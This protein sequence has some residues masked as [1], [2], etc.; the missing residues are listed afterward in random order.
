MSE[1]E[2]TEVEDDTLSESN[3][4]LDI[5]VINEII[6]HEGADTLSLISPYGDGVNWA[7]AKTGTFQVGQKA[8]WIDSVNDPLVPVSNPLFAHM[9]KSA[10]ASG[11]A[12]VKA[13]KLRGVKSRGL[14]IPFDA[15]WEGLTGNQIAKILGIEK[16]KDPAIYGFGGSGGSFHTG[17]AR[18]GPTHLLPT[19]KYDVEGLPKN[20]KMFKN[21]MKVVLTEKVHG[22]N[23]CF[24]YLPFEKQVSE[25]GTVSFKTEFFARSRTLWK[26]PP[27]EDGKNVSLWWDVAKYHDLET[28]LAPYPGIVLWGEAY[29]QVQDLKY[30]LDHAEL[31]VFDVWD[32]NKNRWFTWNE[33][34]EF[35]KTIGLNHVPVIAEVEWNS[36]KGIPKDIIDMSEGTTLLNEAKHVREGI[37]I[38]WDGDN[39]RRAILKLVGTGYLTRKSQPDT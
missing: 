25:D 1:I 37:V 19:S 13:M 23:A 38:R 4:L 12:R 33:V 28:K 21:G 2:N 30:N 36:E 14:I 10:K 26:R 31:I 24:G 6:K 35:C 8:I 27:T 32:S 16:Y 3:P 11:L 29:G 15:E 9:A 22:A 39:G 18:S 34:V 7:I 20:W 17:N 5:I